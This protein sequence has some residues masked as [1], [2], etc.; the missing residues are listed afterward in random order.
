[1]INTADVAGKPI[2]VWSQTIS[3]VS[4]VNP[5]VAFY[6][7]CSGCI[8]ALHKLSGSSIREMRI[9]EKY[10]N[11][12][13][14][15]RHVTL[16]RANLNRA[17]RVYRADQYIYNPTIDSWTA[18]P[19]RTPARRKIFPFRWPS[20]ELATVPTHPWKKGRGVTFLFCL[21]HHKRW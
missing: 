8:V 11:V 13:N 3:G 17:N 20:G 9:S 15:W 12:N 16:R 14:D 5:L 18:V 7:I 2:A 6:D 4:A 21:G 1:M 19:E 10:Y